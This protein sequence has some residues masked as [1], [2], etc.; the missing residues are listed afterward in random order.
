MATR[1]DSRE[2]FF[3]AIQNVGKHL[4]SPAHVSANGLGVWVEQAAS[5]VDLGPS[6]PFDRV[7]VAV[8]Q[9]PRD[10]A[11]AGRIWVVI[12]FGKLRPKG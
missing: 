2:V 1:A 12:L 6:T 9:A 5:E 7:G 10:G 11:L 8:V 3:R 4:V